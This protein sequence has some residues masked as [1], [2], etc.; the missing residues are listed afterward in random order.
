MNEG[1]RSLVICTYIEIAQ[2]DKVSVSAT[3]LWEIPRKGR[4]GIQVSLSWDGKASTHT[5]KIHIVRRQNAMTDAET[6]EQFQGESTVDLD[7]PDTMRV[8]LAATTQP[9]PT[10]LARVQASPATTVPPSFSPRIRALSP[11]CQ[12]GTP[13]N[14][15][16]NTAPATSP[17]KL[18]AFGIATDVQYADLD[19][20][21]SHGGTPR[22]Y[23]NALR[24]LKRAVHSWR[25]EKVDFAMHLGDII[26]G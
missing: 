8:S 14:L 1:R 21:F 24:G 15:S 25:N 4:R 18:F 5:D 6:V 10:L 7:P 23:R 22:Y 16:S 20:G 13:S 11:D 9:G 3:F 2:L 26:D 19:L 12:T 17:D